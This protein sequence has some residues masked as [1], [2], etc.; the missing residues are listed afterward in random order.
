MRLCPALLVLLPFAAVAQQP[1]PASFENENDVLFAPAGATLRRVAE[2]ATDGAGALLVEVKGSEQ[3]TWPGLILRCDPPADWSSLEA[4]QLDITLLGTQPMTLS[5]RLDA[6]GKSVFGGAPV[7]PGLNRDWTVPLAKLGADLHQVS[8]LLLYVRMPRQDWTFAIDHVR[9]LGAAAA[10]ADLIASFETEDDQ[11]LVAGGGAV[12]ERVQERAS[13]GQWSLRVDIKGSETDTWP[14]LY[15]PGGEEPDWSARETLELDIYL[16]GGQAVQLSTRTDDL[17]GHHLFGSLP[18]LKPGWNRG[19]SVNLKAMRPELNLARVKQLLLYV[20]MPRRDIRFYVDRLRWGTF[21]Q[22]F[23]RLVH[24]DPRE[25]IEPTAE[26]RERGFI[27]DSDSY[28]RLVFA[29][30][31]PTGRATGLST[32]ACRGEREPLAIT[33]HALRDLPALELAISELRGPGGTLPPTVWEVRYVRWLDK[34]E[35]YSS[36]TYIAGV[37]SYLALADGPLA[38]RS[39]R[40]ARYVITLTAPRDA[41]P[42]LYRGHVSVA[43]GAGRLELPLQVRLLPFELPEAAGLFYGE[44]YRIRPNEPDVAARIREDLADMRAQG[45]TSVGL[46]F[47]VDPASYTVDGEQVRFEFQGGTPFEHFMTAYR[48]LGFPSPV[49]LLSDSGQAAAASVGKLGDPAYDRVYVNFHRALA[50]ALAER[51]WPAVYVQ[52]VDE[53]GWQD[54]SARERNEHLL[55]L[56]HE[57]GI[58]TEQD[59]PGDDYFHHR[60]GPYAD[61]WNYNGAIGPSDLVAAA[62]D[63]G[64]LVTLYNNDVESYRPEVDRWAY[65]FYNWRHGLHGGFNWE[66]RGGSGDLYD[67]CDAE[68]GDWVHRY[69]PQGD[70]PG[71]PSTGWEGSREGVDDRRYLLL[72][73]SLIAR[74]KAAGGAAAEVAERAATVLADLRSRLSAVPHLRGRARWTAVHTAAEAAQLGLLAPD[75]TVSGVVVGDLKQ[76]NDLSYDEY[77]TLRWLVARQALAVAA[78]L[79]EAVEPS[80]TFRPSPPRERLTV[81]SRDGGEPELAARP[82]LRLPMLPADPTIDGVVDGDPGWRGAAEVG[83]TLSDGAGPPNQPTTVRCGL[84]PGVLHVAFECGEDSLDQIQ[85]HVRELD[86]PVWKDDCVEVFIDPGRTEKSFY[87]V[88]VNSLGTV[89]RSGPKEPPWKPEVRAAAKVEPERQRWTVELAIPVAD[90]PLAPQFGLNFGR[91]RRPL[92]VLE[93]STWSVTGGPFGRPE[94][95]GIAVVEGDAPAAAALPPKIELT[96]SPQWQRAEESATTLTLTAVAPPDQAARAALRVRVEGGPTVV[97]AILPGPVA[98]RTV[99]RLAV[100]DL[101]PGDYRVIAALEG[102]AGEVTATARLTRVAGLGD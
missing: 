95:F 6:G 29:D 101:P 30:D 37:P 94:R 55:R 1:L 52:P 21:A 27:V 60:A 14:G 77:D 45:M 47:G 87:Q 38:V 40:C 81:V 99:A 18:A 23:R 84:R 76:P 26:E 93:L 79:G 44:Y 28:L 85:A 63:R 43:A 74:G 69:L 71:G 11:P 100:G 17:D 56:L 46:C 59:G 2:H 65:G 50:A 68:H 41:A 3:D 97:E 92:E 39:G 58:P 35:T 67:N 19:V 83:L 98:R 54:E 61:I 48:E 22:R 72:A 31:K 34:R 62:L 36:A 10:E 96:L 9:W 8:A 33:V 91:E 5:W 82:V 16:D 12:I 78:A 25:A 88:V 32:F 49:V 80:D 75:P 89:L 51:G 24:V 57:A 4:L 73:E 53:P 20:R 70:E 15:L 7:Q 90:L 13:H 86:G 66:Y 64:H 102:L 42:G